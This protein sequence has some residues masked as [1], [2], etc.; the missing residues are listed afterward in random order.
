MVSD[1]ER[2]HSLLCFVGY[3]W[4]KFCGLLLCEDCFVDTMLRRPTISYQ[5]IEHDF[6][7]LRL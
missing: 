2:S 7:S 1:V 5:P 3:S 4:S 6:I